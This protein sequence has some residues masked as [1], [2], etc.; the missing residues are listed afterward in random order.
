MNIRTTITHTGLL[1]AVLLAGNAVAQEGYS[2]KAIFFGANNQA[3]A[4][5]TSPQPDAQSAPSVT[6]V[7][8]APK[9]APKTVR[10]SIQPPALG[11]SY[12]VRLKQPDGSTRDVLA[13]RTFK[14][15]ERFQLGVKVSRPTYVYIMNEGPDG[16][17]TQLYPAAGQNAMLDAMGVVFLPAQGAFEFDGEPG[18]EQLS[19]LMSPKALGHPADRLRGAKPD[20]VSDPSPRLAAGAPSCSSE[21]LAMASTE[22]SFAAKGVRYT[23][24]STKDS[25]TCAPAY[26]SKAV[27]FSDDPKPAAGG[28]VASYVVKPK[29]KPSDSLHLKLNLVHQ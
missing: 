18:I 1:A 10:K 9:A 13:S 15:G 22:P 25:A 11:A 26:A 14:S 24:D 3:V 19:V 12:F 29:A 7:A 16:K 6:V 23:E 17:L 8:T 20:L 21:R 28:Q 5:S 27:F 2:A 4:L